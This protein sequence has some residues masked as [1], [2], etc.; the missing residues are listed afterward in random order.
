[1]RSLAQRQKTSRPSPFLH[2][3]AAMRKP[4]RKTRTDDCWTSVRTRSS[5]RPSLWWS[6]LRGRC[7]ATTSPRPPSHPSS[8]M[9]RPTWQPGSLVDP[10][11]YAAQPSSAPLKDPPGGPYSGILRRSAGFVTGSGSHDLRCPFPVSGPVGNCPCP[12]P[13]K[14]T[15][16]TTSAHYQDS[17]QG[18]GFACCMPAFSCLTHLD[19]QGDGWTAGAVRPPGPNYDPGSGG[20]PWWSPSPPPRTQCCKGLSQTLAV[21]SLPSTPP[22][23][24]HCGRRGGYS[25]A[26]EP[27]AGPRGPECQGCV[28]DSTPPQHHT[29]HPEWCLCIRSQ[30]AAS[31]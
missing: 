18:V 17:C 3:A 2:P 16:Y 8:C 13:R 27:E 9:G 19:G 14:R 1:M 15:G 31:L 25:S 10:G 24:N 4:G 5:G 28:D 11:E 21:H 12:S 6:V 22:V 26:A 23:A 29:F 7:A 20:N 30:T